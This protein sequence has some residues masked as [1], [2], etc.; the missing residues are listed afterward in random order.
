LYSAKVA[1]TL[2]KFLK[3]SVNIDNYIKTYI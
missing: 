3:K 2:S 1:Y